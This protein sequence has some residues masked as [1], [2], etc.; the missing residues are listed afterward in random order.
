MLRSILTTFFAMAAAALLSAA[1]GCS[2]PENR[3]EEPRPIA[4]SGAPP[5]EPPSYSDARRIDTIAAALIAGGKV[6]LFLVGSRDSAT[7][8]G[9]LDLLEI[10]AY[11]SLGKSWSRVLSDSVDGAVHLELDDLTGDGQPEVILRL[12]HGGNDPISTHGMHVYTAHG[13]AVRRVFRSSWMDPRIDSVTGIAGTVILVRQSLWPL[14]APRSDATLYT[15]DIFAYR[16]GRF[17]SVI[18]EAHV[19]F[20]A[21]A[22]SAAARY[23]P[24]RDSIERQLELRRRDRRRRRD[25]IED[26]V[27]LEQIPAAEADSILGA[28][29]LE[30]DTLPYQQELGLY[31]STALVVLNRVRSGEERAAR[32]FWGQHRSFLRSVLR[33]EQ[34]DELSAFTEQLL[35]PG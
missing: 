16:E 12:D 15:D 6:P 33:E 28:I 13:G 20:R 31:R 27:R 34:Y 7:P 9:R 30:R 24:L 26:L 21:E 2:E 14:F 3:P 29:A 5:F 11:D 22:D 18:A 19:Y 1:G 23:R 32:S 4:S 35:S 10:Y 25:S 8:E 17:R